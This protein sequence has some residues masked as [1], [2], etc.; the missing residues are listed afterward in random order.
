MVVS[1]FHGGSLMATTKEILIHGQKVNRV[2]ERVLRTLIFLRRPVTVPEISGI[3]REEFSDMKLYSILGGLKKKG[4]LVVLTET[5]IER[6]GA[7]L[8]RRQWE[9][10]TPVK[11]YFSSLGR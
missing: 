6:P 9:A 3:L 2:E 4:G 1:D 7:T 10:S 8:T 11:D 5:N